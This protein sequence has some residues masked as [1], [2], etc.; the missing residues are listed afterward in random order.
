MNNMPAN[1]GWIWFKEGVGLFRKQPAALTTL[2]FANIL[3]AAVV[4]VIPVLSVAT[5][6]LIPSLSMAVMMAC[7]MIENGQRVTPAVLLTGFRQPVLLRLCKVGLI[8]VAAWLVLGLLERVLV[9][10][11][12]YQQIPQSLEM[13]DAQQAQ[14]PFGAMLTLMFIR[15]MYIVTLIALAFAAPLAYWQQMGPGKAVFYSFFAVFRNLRVFLVLLLSWFG[16]M[17]AVFMTLLILLGGGKAAFVAV[18][19]VLF[20]APDLPTALR[21]LGGLVGQAPL[22]AGL[23]WRTLAPAAALAC[24]GPTAWTVVQRTPPG[25]LAALGFGLLF[26]ALLL[27]IGEDANYAFIYF[28]F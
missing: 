1:T 3:F 26:V 19:W 14:V 17:F 4:G 5:N 18:T 12:I 13:K 20:R 23:S 10:P 9:D 22:G 8:Y 2:L 16:I 25:R 7:L 21:I 11:A 6:V 15:T 27:R 28:Q 24:L